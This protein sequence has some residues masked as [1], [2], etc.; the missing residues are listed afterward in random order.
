MNKFTEGIRR[1]TGI[2]TPVGGI[3]WTPSMSERKTIYNFW[4]TLADR[5]ILYESKCK[6]PCEQMVTSV[7][8]IRNMI[9]STLK[10][11]SPESS[12][13]SL[14]EEMRTACHE[15]QMYLEEVFQSKSDEEKVACGSEFNES[16]SELREVFRKNI[17]KLD[18]S[19]DLN[20]RI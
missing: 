17:G 6:V 12:I 9:T 8:A 4:Q 18:E 15:F 19:F 5:R 11:L 13:R 20:A 10:E 3:S 16:I 2:S 1:I 14:L 7:E